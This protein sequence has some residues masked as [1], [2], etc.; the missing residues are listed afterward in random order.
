MKPVRTAV[1]V[2]SLL[3]VGVLAAPPASAATK[4]IVVNGYQHVLDGTNVPRGP[5]DLIRYT[6]ARERTGTNQYGFEVKLVH[7]T[8]VKRV[9]KVGNM[10]IPDDGS[11]LSGNGR[12]RTWLMNHVRIGDHV[13]VVDGTP[14]LPDLGVRTLRGFTITNADGVKQLRFPGVTAN[15][16]AGPFEIRGTRSSTSDTTWDM[17]QTIYNSNGTKQSHATPGPTLYFA[18]DGHAHWHVRDLDSYELLNASGTE[19]AVGEKHGFCFQDNT[20]YKDWPGQHAGSPA[21]PVYESGVVCGAHKPDALTVKQ[22]ISVGWADTYASTLRDQYIDIS[23][24][25][26]GDYRVQITADWADWFDEK[27]EA[28]NTSWAT[29]RI[30]GNT[31]TRL[32]TGGGL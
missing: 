10:V 21:S 4:K 6:P 2:A 31:V 19:V 12:A 20:K 16:G 1:V 26:D 15:V 5:D 17:V 28:N 13:R 7:G 27:N 18:G 8:V 9:D 24:L 3:L 11:V 32:D 30:S 25:P 22:G 23:G 14:L 29:I